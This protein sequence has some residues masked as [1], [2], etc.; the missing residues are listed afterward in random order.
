MIVYKLTDKNGRTR[1]STQWDLGISHEPKGNPNQDLC[2]DGWIH[3]YTDPLVAVLMGPIHGPFRMGARLWVAKAEG[4][5]KTEGEES[6]ILQGGSRKVTMIEEI[7]LP[8]IPHEARVRIAIKLAQ[9]ITGD[10]YPEWVEWAMG[11]LSGKDRSREPAIE[12]VN[13][14]NDDVEADAWCVAR[15]ASCA[16]ADT[17]WNA[18]TETAW[19][20]DYIISQSDNLAGEIDIDL[21]ALI[22]EAIKKEEKI[23]YDKT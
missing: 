20:A 3:W 22:R 13:K 23:K 16:A 8:K 5:I 21:P 14:I 2:S 19:I 10:R 9:K 11:W 15:A 18:A 12:L 17:T 7:S 6:F 1:G 4:E